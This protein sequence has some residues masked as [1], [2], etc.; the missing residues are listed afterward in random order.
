MALHS[1][2]KLIIL[3]D[4]RM[5]SEK[6]LGNMPDPTPEDLQSSEFEAIWQCIKSWD[7]NVPEFY[8]GYCGATGSHVKL[9]LNALRNAGAH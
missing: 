7:V 8:S 5:T 1:T 3:R 9:I 2:D 4:E 6:P